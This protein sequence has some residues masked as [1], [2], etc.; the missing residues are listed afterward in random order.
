LA[1]RLSLIALKR[2]SWVDSSVFILQLYETQVKNPILK[3]FIFEILS[4]ERIKFF[5]AKNA[6]HRK[7]F[8]ENCHNLQIFRN[9]KLIFTKSEIE[10]PVAKSGKSIFTKVDFAAACNRFIMLLTGYNFVS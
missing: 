7:E 3:E 5:F 9:K 2:D 4:P 1:G 6:N 8:C 10:S